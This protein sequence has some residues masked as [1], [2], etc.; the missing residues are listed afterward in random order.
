MLSG[1]AAEWS[2]VPACTQK[3]NGKMAS[4]GFLTFIGA[5]NGPDN[6]FIETGCNIL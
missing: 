3:N 5:L 4:A 1:F 6:F 2:F